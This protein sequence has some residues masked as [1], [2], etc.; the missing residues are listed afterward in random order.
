MPTLCLDVHRM[1]W[2]VLFSVSQPRASPY[3][4][5]PCPWR[6]ATTVDFEVYQASSRVLALRCP[7]P[8][9]R[10]THASQDDVSWRTGSRL[11]VKWRK[12]R[13][14]V[15]REAEVGSA[16]RQ[17]ASD[18]G[19]GDWRQWKPVSFVQSCGVVVSW[20]SPNTEGLRSVLE[21]GRF[22]YNS[23]LVFMCNTS[24]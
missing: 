19:G 18:V 8:R 12:K 22:S 16:G 3:L 1:D 10:C 6:V 15:R 23:S 4:P 20:I 11:V 14:G 2:S 7:S 17:W 9:G 13:L 21:K 24:S 5:G